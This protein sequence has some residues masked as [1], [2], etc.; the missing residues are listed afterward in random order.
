MD[1]IKFVLVSVFVSLCLLAH[2]Q[3]IPP[4]AVVQGQLDAYN[5]Q[6]V[7]AFADLFA[8]DAEIFRN[9]GDEE[10]YLEGRRKIRKQYKELFKENPQNKSTLIGR[11]VQG[12]YVIDHE[13]ITGR[14][15]E[16]KIVAIYEVQNGLIR[17]AWFVR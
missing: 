13:W 4:V 8:E 3:G 10:P 2:A 16:L 14:A 15:E 1:L 12:N 11:I 5:A 17:R 6:D 7:D 9:I